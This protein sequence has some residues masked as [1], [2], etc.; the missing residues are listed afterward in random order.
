MTVRPAIEG[1]I[2]AVT[3]IYAHYVLN[4][5]STFEFEPPTPAEMADRFEAI[6]SLNLPYLV[7]ETEGAVAGYAYAGPFRPRPAYRFTVEDSIYLSP[8]WRGRGLGQMLL[9][10][11]ISR[12][13]QCGSRQMVAII[14]DTG[15]TASVRLHAKLGFRE[16]G[17]LDAVGLKFGR[18]IDTVL[19]QRPLGNGAGSLP[20]SSDDDVS[21]D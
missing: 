10:D 16:V 13:E 14:G 15:N 1:D 9:E 20:A 7:I 21:A 2:E 19:M 6:I 17:T 11:L 12:C 8:E 5:T 3:A 4:G 18:W